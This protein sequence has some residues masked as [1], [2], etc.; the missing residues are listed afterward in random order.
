LTVGL[1]F[2]R[3]VLSVT[4]EVFVGLRFEGTPFGNIEGSDKDLFLDEAA[5]FYATFYFFLGLFSLLSPLYLLK[6]YPL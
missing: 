1:C 3:N 5:T 2:S 4:I 6:R